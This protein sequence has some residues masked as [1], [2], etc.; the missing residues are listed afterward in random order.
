MNS[1]QLDLR[2]IIEDAKKSSVPSLKYLC[3]IRCSI[4]LCNQKEVRDLL[5][6]LKCPKKPSLRLTI[7]SQVEWQT[8]NKI[9]IDRLNSILIPK[10]LKDKILSYSFPITLEI[11]KWI[12]LYQSYELPEEFC[13]TVK[14]TIDYKNTTKRIIKNESV[15]IKKRFVLSCI[16]CLETDIFLLWIDMPFGDKNYFINKVRNPIIF[17][18]VI[19]MCAPREKALLFDIDR[20]FQEAFHYVVERGYL[21]AVKYFT[22]KLHID[23]RQRFLEEIFNHIVD[24]KQ[25]KTHV[26]I[27]EAKEADTWFFLFLHM[28]K[29]LQLKY[30]QNKCSLEVIFHMFF[31]SGRQKYLIML[32][33]LVSENMESYHYSDIGFLIREKYLLEYKDCNYRKTF[34]QFWSEI[35]NSKRQFLQ[36]NKFLGANFLANLIKFY[37]TFLLEKGTMKSKG[38]HISKFLKSNKLSRH[39]CFDRD[40]WKLLLFLI[41]DQVVT[42]RDFKLYKPAFLKAFSIHPEKEQLW[43]RTLLLIRRIANKR[44]RSQINRLPTK[45]LQEC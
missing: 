22:Y 27:P 35:P 39:C 18:W 17:Y 21:D 2:T 23:A 44:V 12:E 20:V 5:K 45:K 8:I 41:Q 30:F 34:I 31:S 6:C 37:F 11:L 42:W 38:E 24:A 19:T 3:V 25:K 9:I 13:W 10:P 43:K 1:Q 4:E 33:N 15:C 40:K 32:M 29:D 36:R 28:T 16:Y 7:K 26:G 14:G